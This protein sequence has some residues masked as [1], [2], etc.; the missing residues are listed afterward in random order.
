MSNSF[1]LFLIGILE[2]ILP[3]VRINLQ[4]IAQCVSI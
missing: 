3:F 4:Q 1:C 2:I